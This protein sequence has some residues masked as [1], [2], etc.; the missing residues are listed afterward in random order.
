MLATAARARA[1]LDGRDF[2]LPDDVKEL[3][4]PA[5]RP[6]GGPRPRFGGRGPDRA[7]ACSSR[8][9]SR[10]PHRDD[11]AH[12]ALRPALRGGRAPRV[13]ARS[14]RGV[15]LARLGLVVGA[16]LAALAAERMLALG[17]DDLTLD[18][19]VPPRSTSA[20]ATCCASTSPRAPPAPSRWRSCAIST[21][22]SKLSLR[23]TSRWE[24]DSRGRGQS[25]SY[26]VVGARRT[27][28]R[29]GSAGPA[30]SACFNGRSCGRSGVSC[31][32]FPTSRA[33]RGAALRFFEPPAVPDR[34]Q[35]WSATWATAPSSS[36][37]ASISRGSTRARS[38]GRPRL[39]TTSS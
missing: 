2:V 21:S 6:S 20:I 5:A 9:S 32:S 14:R 29:P 24:A 1:A 34:S 28:S 23:R 36:R 25:R 39:A 17:P 16:T 30:R 7:R 13:A 3:A 18:A 19:A 37:C 4:V 33:V 38:T 31:G 22:F 12:P 26:R 35:G 10:C 11:P 8:S 15:S 27:W